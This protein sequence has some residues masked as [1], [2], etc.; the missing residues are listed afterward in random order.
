MRGGKKTIKKNWIKCQTKSAGYFLL[1]KKN[2]D[3]LIPLVVHI[4]IQT[5]EERTRRLFHVW[6]SPFRKKSLETGD[7]PWLQSRSQSRRHSAAA[8]MPLWDE[9]EISSGR[10][11]SHKILPS[12]TL[13]TSD[14]GM[15]SRLLWFGRGGL[16]VDRGH[17]V[18]AVLLGFEPQVGDAVG[19]VHPLGCVGVGAGRRVGG[20]GTAR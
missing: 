14:V 7:H 15:P 20:H 2:K 9:Q 3:R 10:E 5:P 12:A 17:L 16:S 11:E 1:Q 8:S 19:H 6:E 13:Q 18:Q 4:S